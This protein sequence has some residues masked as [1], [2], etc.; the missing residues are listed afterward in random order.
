MVE[1]GEQI[2]SINPVIDSV[3]DIDSVQIGPFAGRAVTNTLID[4]LTTEIRSFKMPE[5]RDVVKALK[6]QH[7]FVSLNYEANMRV[8]DTISQANMRNMPNVYQD[9]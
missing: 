9:S 2:T 4:L 5:D 6:E 7:A 8:C 1:S 3:L